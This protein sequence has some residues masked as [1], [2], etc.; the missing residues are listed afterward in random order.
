[1]PARINTAV[2]RW[3]GQVYWGDATAQLGP[4]V[5]LPV[6][7]A[8]TK[9][10]HV[11]EDGKLALVST[12]TMLFFV[13]L[14]AFI[15][16]AGVAIKRK[17]DLQNA[18][19]SAAYSTALWMARGM[20]SVTVANHMMG[21][22]TAL[23]TIV[24]SFGGDL[25]AKGGSES[26]TESSAFN[27]KIKLAAI[28]AALNG[29]AMRSSL[30]SLDQPLVD[31][32]KD[33]VTEDDGKHTAAATFYDAQLTLKYVTLVSFTVKTVSNLV[34]D[35]TF[36]IPF[37]IGPA[38][39]GAVIGIHTFI[40]GTILTRVLAEWEG[41]KAMETVVQGMEQTR[42]ALR[43]GLIPAL[44][45]YADTVAGKGVGDLGG[46]GAADVVGNVGPI[47]TSAQK[48]LDQLQQQLG[49]GIQ[50]QVFP[51]A[52]KL[53]LPIVEEPP[54]TGG[55]TNE[56]PPSLWSKKFDVDPAMVAL[57]AMYD[58]LRGKVKAFTDVVDGILGA[59]SSIVGALGDLVGIDTGVLTKAVDGLKNAAKSL[60]SPL[61]DEPDYE[62][63]FPEN[64]SQKQ[65][66]RFRLP[67]FDWKAERNSQWVRG[68]YPYV[69]SFRGPI[70]NFFDNFLWK[71]SAV[72]HYYVHWCNRYT[73]ANSFLIRSGKD[74]QAA[75]MYI[76]QDS[77]PDKKGYEPWTT[78]AKAAE[79]MFTVSAIAQRV[80]L[81]AHFG[82]VIYSDNNTKGTITLASAMF[83]NANDRNVPKGGPQT[84]AEQRNTGW[85][86]LNW[87]PPVTAPEWGDHTVDERDENPVAVFT[88]ELDA[89]PNARVQINWQAKLVPMMAE[90]K[91]PSALTDGV[92]DASSKLDGNGRDLLR[93]VLDHSTLLKH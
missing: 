10:W 66:S 81:Q 56:I 33:E 88:D 87:L 14:I 92:N 6:V 80:P 73:L 68:T 42:T 3:L 45:F 91:P 59:A 2:R 82:P 85:D 31:K 36:W 22:A 27:T 71:L 38:I 61:P 8:P 52:D 29:P 93:Q 30:N 51:A 21:E 54:P 9:S 32:V 58:A 62:H 17:M 39:E 16:N 55:A 89:A 41:L 37:G 1:M 19:D 7:S 84:S 26:T 12:V 48:T 64:P 47:N 67:E 57:Q 69:N 24:D 65:G 86:T 28:H 5:E 74:G 43:E 34:A 4:Q 15:G 76:M 63:G 75:H 25:L 72:D 90:G 35:V 70:F 78:D 20:N 50:L 46:G 40:S 44:S 53:K 23:M 49:G 13:I 18:A 79:K 83:Y 11:D 60:A 77:S